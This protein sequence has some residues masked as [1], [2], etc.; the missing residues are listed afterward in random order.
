MMNKLS[1][2]IYSRSV[3]CFEEAYDAIGR[4]RLIIDSP[5]YAPKHT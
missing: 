5:F 2:S 1:L 4:G 3:I